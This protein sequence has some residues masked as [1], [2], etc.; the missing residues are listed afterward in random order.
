MLPVLGRPLVARVMTPL[1]ESGVE[2]F[3][4]VIQPGD[5]ALRAY[6]EGAERQPC[7]VHLVDQPE[8]LGTADA[9]QRAAGLIQGPFLLSACDSVFPG[10][11]LRRLFNRWRQE[12]P[13]ALLSLMS[14]SSER[15][16]K[17]GVVALDGDRVTE[18]VEKPGR[19]EAPSNVIS[20]PLYI[21]SSRVLAYLPKVSRSV[22]GEFEIQS[23]IQMMIQEGEK[24]QGVFLEN[25]WEVTTREDLL[26]INLAF[27]TREAPA[28][29]GL[30]DNASG[31]IQLIPPFYIEADA[32]IGSG[33]SMGPNVYAEKDCRIG[34][35]ARLDH[36][37]VLGG[38][39]VPDGGHG[40]HVLVT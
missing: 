21:F 25:R 18:M 31:R 16:S 4:L 38:G 29:C 36:A 9:L 12:T 37:V 32:R 26:A 6:F 19:E 28:Y 33:C 1:I 20:T 3:I 27:L 14:A 30:K 24:V 35:G 10:D 7:R 2:E 8:P 15:L 40:H 11:E 13:R 23:A 17:S 39:T 22:R 34:P 5:D